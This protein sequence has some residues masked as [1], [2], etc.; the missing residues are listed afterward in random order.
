MKYRLHYEMKV[1][2]LCTG[3][4]RDEANSLATREWNGEKINGRENHVPARLKNYS[5]VSVFKARG[6][7][8]FVCGNV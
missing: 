3:Y 7:C 8:V 1:M 5:R 6:F 4:T 2:E